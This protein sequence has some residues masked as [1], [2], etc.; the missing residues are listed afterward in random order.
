MVFLLPLFFA[1][2]G[3]GSNQSGKDNSD[4]ASAGTAVHTEAEGKVAGRSS[5]SGLAYIEQY[6]GQ[7][8]AGAGLWETEPL[9]TMLKE[10]LGADF[11]LYL[12]VMQEAMPLQKDRVIY[13]VGVAPDD[14]IPGVGYL[15]IDT[16]NDKIRAFAVFGD[17]EIEVQ[18]EG[19]D[20]DI[21]EAVKKKVQEVLG[22]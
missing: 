3:C 22:R 17:A 4:E 20:L 21:P 14:Q 15:L 12:D 1:L 6:I 7:R 10:L 8:P 5:Q 16:E 19:G 18:S 11:D 13:T 9:R 2:T